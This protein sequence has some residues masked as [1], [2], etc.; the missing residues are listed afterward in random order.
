VEPGHA[1]AQ[2]SHYIH[3]NPVRARILPL[4]SLGEYP[5]SSLQ[6]FPAPNRPSWLKSD[7]ILREAGGFSDDA[8]GWRKYVEYLGVIAADLADG[9]EKF[10]RGWL[11]GSTEF[12]AKLNAELM[13]Q[14]GFELF[15]A[16]Q[17]TLRQARSQLWE[18]SM[19]DLAAAGGNRPR[20]P[21]AT[22]IRLL[23]NWIFRGRVGRG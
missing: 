7:T 9:R 3:L 20:R 1:L 17:T 12:A 22:K 13:Q 11:V 23:G 21:A 18:D 4:A 10:S 5:W 15:G 14:P 2:V 6:C 8:N 16:D 19:R